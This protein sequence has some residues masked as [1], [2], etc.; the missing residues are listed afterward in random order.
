MTA[1]YKVF[2]PAPLEASD[3]EEFKIAQINTARKIVFNSVLQIDQPT[4]SSLSIKIMGRSYKSFH[5]KFTRESKQF[6]ILKSFFS[7]FPIGF[8]NK[9]YTSIQ[10]S[11]REFGENIFEPDYELSQGLGL[12]T[13]SQPILTI[14][15]PVYNNWWVTYRCLRSLQA[16]TDKVPF[17]VVIVDDASTD[18]TQE[19]L[20][21]I[22]GVTVVRNTINRG[23]L[24]STNLGASNASKSSTHIVLLNNDTEPL[25]GWLDELYETIESDEAI[26]IV[27][28]ALI[29][30]NGTLQE[31]GGQ[32][33]ANGN[34]WNLGRGE[35]PLKPIFSFRREVDYCS[36]ASIIVRKSFWLEVQ[37]FDT[38]YS[39]AYCEDSDLALCAWN[40][41]MKV[42]YEPKSWVIHHEGLSHGKSTSAGQ[43]SYQLENNRKLF[44][45]WELSLNNHWEDRGFSRLEATRNSKGI[46]VICDRDIPSITRD[47]G[48]VRTIQII[49][50]LQTLG[51]HVVFNS[52]N[53]K[54]T[55]WDLLS[56]QS[57]GVEV[58]LDTTFFYDSLST[59]RERVV[60]FWT[61]RQEVYEYFSKHLKEIAPNAIFIADLMDLRY[62]KE[63]K[64]NSG[65]SESQ[66]R[67]AS[68]VD[69]VIL[70]S[71]TEANQYRSQTKLNN[72]SVIWAEYEPH[73]DEIK[74]EDTNG[75][76]FVGSFKH[77][78][79][80]EGLTWF[81]H[82]VL[83]ELNKIG[84]NAPIRIVGSGLS[85]AQSEE[86]QSKGFKILGRKENLS[87]LYL[88]SR[89]AICPLLRG[90]GRKGK[91][92]EALS[93]A[94]PVVATSIGVQGFGLVE[95]SGI[96]ITDSPAEMAQQIYM[97]H[98][99]RE[100]WQIASNMAK[101]YCKSHLGSQALQSQ[102]SELLLVESS[103]DV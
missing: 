94:I 50:H 23:Y 56:L 64:E 51:Y 16:N 38:R 27:G 84:F 67:I 57:A 43:K 66:L 5:S 99:Q 42:I 63:F 18:Q 3:F 87:E 14:V 65:I 92:G 24:L 68:E 17:E 29:Y 12:P 34:A 96:T 72:T 83:P 102:I 103:R 8:R 30:P 91:I 88:Q 44:S 98:H 69:R 19:A 7:F 70:V 40:M 53:S 10:F 4:K 9:I 41:G 26:A 55:T 82:S 89:I 73:E 71:E 75:L 6:H 59:R 35:S 81:A 2:P 32:I 20:N 37:G 28:S 77:L 13:S 58:H 39:P 36:A 61:I 31:A 95:E 80:L 60:L 97:L 25:S 22:R 93:F 62:V 74:W 21:S 90:A 45:K 100:P 85:A 49:K 101:I 52:L 1:N 78:P 47:A 33:F 48:S 86:F 11:G 15:I 76:I 79:N 46:V 54:A